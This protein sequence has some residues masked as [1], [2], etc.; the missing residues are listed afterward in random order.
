MTNERH[1]LF[2]LLPGRPSD[3]EGEKRE[4]MAG[5]LGRCPGLKV[6]SPPAFGG[7]R[8]INGPDSQCHDLRPHPAKPMANILLDKSALR[9]CNRERLA[10]LAKGHLV[11][12]PQVLWYEIATEDPA[13]CVDPYADY[14]AKLAGLKFAVCRRVVDIEAVEK[15]TGHPVTGIVD[16]WITRMAQQQAERPRQAWPQGTDVVSPS[17][18][19][20]QEEEILNWR[21]E[22][23]SLLRGAQSLSGLAK[24]VERVAAGD[25]VDRERALAIISK[26]AAV[27]R[28]AAIHPGLQN[29][30]CDQSV[31]FTNFWLQ[32][33]LNFR[34]L[35]YGSKVGDKQL[36]NETFDSEYI[37]LLAVADGLASNDRV[38]VQIA[39][40]L[41]P[42]KEFS[43]WL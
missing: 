40:A 42:N 10:T 1:F 37:I 20:T 34:R 21:R 7:Q 33:Y 3:P 38:M 15:S 12:L 18:A 13:G 9:G 39:K 16:D 28:W 27:R 24:E 11:L 6:G 2:S 17:N 26:P 41:F 31:A 36:V 8:P 14:F 35:M 5:A 25:N 43:T 19:R 23:L 29:L 30:A 4:R 22:R 32:T